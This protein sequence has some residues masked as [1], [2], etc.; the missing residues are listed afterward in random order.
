MTGYAARVMGVKKKKKRLNFR[1]RYKWFG[2]SPR[3]QHSWCKC[4]SI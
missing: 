4:S 3:A 2:C 1:S